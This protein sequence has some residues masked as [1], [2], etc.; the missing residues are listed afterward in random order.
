MSC[1][2]KAGK[3]R[4]ILPKAHLAKWAWQNIEK[5]GAMVIEEVSEDNKKLVEMFGARRL[6]EIKNLPDFYTFKN[7]SIY[8]HRDFDIFMKNLGKGEKSAIVSG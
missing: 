4:R 3:R 2:F 7:G 1:K 5:C 6:S 8:S